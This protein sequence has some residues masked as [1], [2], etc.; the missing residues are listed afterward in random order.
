MDWVAAAASEAQTS[1]VLRIRD[2]ASK[3]C[4]SGSA[5]AKAL[6]RLKRR[7]LAEQ[8]TSDTYLN[9]LAPAVAHGDLLNSLVPD[10]YV[11]LGTALADWGISSQA[12]V[13]TSAVSPTKLRKIKSFS[14]DI[15]YRKIHRDLFWGFLEKKG[16]YATYKIAE[17][18]KALLDWIYFRLKDGLPVEF[19]EMHFDKLSRSRLVGYA[20]KFPNS[21]I[22]TLFFPML[23]GEIANLQP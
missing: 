5:V 19:D 4:L 12:P 14:V 9:R 8:L 11:S 15:L 21:V 22:Q 18:E 23:E 17:P 10:A 20:K 16:R 1:P 13:S 2:L 3:Y 6:S 7:G